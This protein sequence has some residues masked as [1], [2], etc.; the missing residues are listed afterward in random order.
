MLF[1]Q[2]LW[3]I[4]L[5][6]S[7]VIIVSAA[8]AWLLRFE[9]N[10]PR[11]GEFFLALP[12]LLLMR[13]SF[14]AHFKLFHGYWRYTGVNDALDVVKAVGA[15]SVAFLVVERWVMGGKSFSL[16]VCCIEMILTTV[17][18]IAVRVGSRALVQSTQ[19]HA[20]QRDNKTV[21]V[22]GAGCAAAMLLRELPR[23]GYTA[24][25]LVDDDPA[26]AGVKLHGIPVRGSV[27]DLVDVVKG[28][29]PDEI[30]IAIPSGTREQMRRIAEYCDRTKL[31][32]R[33]IPSLGDLI[34]GMVTVDQLREVNL[35]DLLGR[36]PVH[37]NL[38]SVRQ[39]VA[40]RVVMVTGA[41]GSIGSEL[42]RQLLGYAPAK[43]VCVDQAET[44]LFYLEHANSESEA[45]KIYCVAD[46]TDSSRMR[47]IILGHDVTVIFHA[48]AYKHVPMMEENLQEAVKNN[49]FGLLSLMEVAAQSGCEDF[50]FIS[51]DKAVNPTSFMGCTKRI[52]ELIV[53]S[54]PC[55]QMRC[56]SVRF[57]N[58]LG[59]QGSVI[60][61]FQQQIK[62]SRRITVT[63]RDVTRYFMTV[64]EAVS[65]V[66][67]AF[68]IGGNGNVLVLDMGKPIRILDIAKTLIRLSGIP[69]DDVEIVF[70]GLRPG[71]KLFEDLFYQSEQRLSTLAQKVLRTEGALLSWPELRVRLSALRAECMTGISVR[72]RRSVKEIVPQYQWT[73][74]DGGQGIS[75]A[76]LAVQRTYNEKRELIEPVPL[77]L[78]RDLVVAIGPLQSSESQTQNV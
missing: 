58:V 7:V 16:S 4:V 51:S 39:R 6:Q 34:Q 30:M 21:V 49:V 53:A 29:R 56:L 18:L 71:E 3:A 48:A 60:P 59:S 72:I 11:P 38:D 44:P 8:V 78:D 54:R 24:L 20:V 68:S 40:G 17:A 43:L 37:L 32:Y 28:Y 10:F 19:A 35:D 61:L 50:L 74:S 62:S 5:F 65:L 1:K 22:I 14:M 67:Q 9:F 63:H 42:C 2:R 66:L 33:T 36:E 13:L 73:P 26:K 15:G 69:E 52:G 31:P 70:T 76:A 25:A 23:S 77:G 41:A 45:A 75:S 64:P 12:L 46:I 27:V 47:D 57:G 55:A